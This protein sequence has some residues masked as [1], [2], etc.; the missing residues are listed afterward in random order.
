MTDGSADDAP[1]IVMLTAAT[2]EM[3]TSRGLEYSVCYP[4]ARSSR[5]RLFERS[6]FGV[7]GCYI[8]VLQKRRPAPKARHEDRKR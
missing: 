5:Q 8:G 2:F 4:N 7:G 6:G 3:P 1:P